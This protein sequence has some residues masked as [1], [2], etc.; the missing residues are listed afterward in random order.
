MLEDYGYISIEYITFIYK[1]NLSDIQENA[2][3]QYRVMP[4]IILVVILFTWIF[5]RYKILLIMFSN[6]S[7]TDLQGYYRIENPA[8]SQNIPQFYGTNTTISP[9]KPKNLPKRY[10]C[11]VCGKVFSAPAFL[12]R[13][14]RVHTG[15]RPFECDICG[16]RFTQAGNLGSHRI[17]HTKANLK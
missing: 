8:Y 4:Q 6:Y 17:L 3:S 15:E 7:L 13:H 2:Y 14:R 10:G 5:T 9:T 11:S 16:K 12:R 1:L